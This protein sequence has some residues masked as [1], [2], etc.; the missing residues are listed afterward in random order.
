MSLKRRRRR[1]DNRLSKNL[2]QSLAEKG[3]YHFKNYH[4]ITFVK[5]KMDME[6]DINPREF[7]TFK[8]Y[9]VVLSTIEEYEELRQLMNDSKLLVKTLSLFDENQI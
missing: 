6:R 1:M 5:L 2:F 4:Y 8:N 7:K 9:I 3:Y